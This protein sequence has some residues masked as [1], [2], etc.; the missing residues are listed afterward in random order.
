[1]SEWISVKDSL[2][3][4]DSFVVAAHLYEYGSDTDACICNFY[5]GEFRVNSDG[6]EAYGGAMIEMNFDPTHWMPLPGPPNE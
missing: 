6:L 1:M 4:E 3:A 5:Y 2:P